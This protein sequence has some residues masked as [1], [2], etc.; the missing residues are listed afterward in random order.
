MS[1]FSRLKELEM[2]APAAN[3]AEL[4]RPTTQADVQKAKFVDDPR[5]PVK[6]PIDDKMGLISPNRVP[7]LP[8]AGGGAIVQNQTTGEIYGD[9]N[10]DMGLNT[11]SPTVNPPGEGSTWGDKLVHG[12]GGAAD[13]AN[14]NPFGMQ[15]LPQSQYQG[16][17]DMLDSMDNYKKASWEITK[18][19]VQGNFYQAVGAVEGVMKGVGGWVKNLHPY[20]KEGY[21]GVFEKDGFFDQLHNVIGTERMNRMDNREMGR[22][23]GEIAGSFIPIT[24]S[25]KIAHQLLNRGTQ[26]LEFGLGLAKAGFGVGKT[27][28]AGGI[29]GGLWQFGMDKE[30]GREFGEDV[31]KYLPDGPWREPVL[32]E[33]MDLAF[34]YGIGGIFSARLMASKAGRQEATQK[35]KSLF[36]NAKKRVPQDLHGKLGDLAANAIEESHLLNTKEKEFLLESIEQQGM[37][38]ADF[39]AMVETAYKGDKAASEA[40]MRAGDDVFGASVPGGA[41]PHGVSD[42]EFRMARDMAAARKKPIRVKKK[43]SK[44]IETIDVKQQRTLRTPGGKVIGDKVMLGGKE[45][46]VG[47]ATKAGYVLHRGKQTIRIGPDKLAKLKRAKPKKAKKPKPYKPPQPKD[48]ATDWRLSR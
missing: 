38:H 46:R 13:W 14:S 25:Y 37:S 34:V 41:S 19:L 6:S 5:P 12:A 32:F 3:Q 15:P 1:V 23:V 26:G 4:M 20:F 29:A 43:P 40:I 21:E 31:E 27:A 42:I 8:S 39:N 35:F 10:I 2:G 18:E 36:E 28:A 16:R 45:Y 44:D 22:S 24:K 33:V 47:K 17:P 30:H 9:P 48:I 11:M 7:I